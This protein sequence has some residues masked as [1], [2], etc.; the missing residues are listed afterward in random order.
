M[1]GNKINALL[2]LHSEGRFLVGHERVKLLEKVAELGSIAKAAKATG[3]SY[4]TAWDS[5]NAVNNLL[6]TPA[7]L[8]RPGGRSGGGAEVTEE[9]RRLIATFHRLEE[10]LSRISNL[11]AEEGLEGQE[12]A[13]LWTLGARIS[14]RNVFQTE[15]SHVKRWP[16][17]VEITLKFAEGQKFLAIVTNE[18]ADDLE[19]AVGKKALALVKSSFIRLYAP[20][21]APRDDRNAFIGEV[22]DRTDA[23]RNTEI[24]LDIGHGKTLHAV[25]PRQTAEDLGLEVGA[26]AAATFDPSQVILA[27]N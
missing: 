9:G 22:T 11:I 18:A 5:V 24:R 15:V 23:E 10:K 7:F 1:T 4:K 6:P 13:F 3:F 8:T 14:A 2:A 12:E 21:N 25:V 27:V 26:K 16:V 20:Q 19:L 17:D